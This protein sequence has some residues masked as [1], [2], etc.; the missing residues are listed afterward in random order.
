VAAEVDEDIDLVRAHQGRELLVGKRRHVVP[1]I[2]QGRDA[3]GDAV[4]AG[5]GEVTVDFE[6]RAI[7]VLENRL[8]VLADDVGAKLRRDVAEPE[9]AARIRDV[10]ERRRRREEWPLEASR[11]LAVLRVNVGRREIRPTHHEKEQVLKREHRAAVV[12]D[13][14]L[15]VPQGVAVARLV[16]KDVGE[17]AVRAGGVRVAEAAL[18]SAA[19]G[20]TVEL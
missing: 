4:M 3:L 18:D 14:E 2:D 9:A 1:V 15:V 5:A 6:L 13:G 20:A 16:A 7:V 8:H 11:E 19:K 17:Q 10:T 12:K